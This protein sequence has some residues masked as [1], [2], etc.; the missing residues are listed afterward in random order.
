MAGKLPTFFECVLVLGGM[1]IR[2]GVSIARSSRCTMALR[3]ISRDARLVHS[4]E[5]YNLR[6]PGQYFDSETGKHYNYFR[7]YDPALGRYVES[8]LIGLSGGLNTYSYVWQAP[9]SYLDPHGLECWWLDQGNAVQ[10]K[11]TGLRRQKPTGRYMAKQFFPAPDPTSP[12]IAIGPKPPMPQPGMQLVWRT[13]FHDKGYWEA[14]FS[15]HSWATYVCKE[16]CGKLTF[17]PGNMDLGKKW[18]AVPH[19][20]YDDLSYGPWSNVTTPTGPWDLEGVHGPRSRG[21]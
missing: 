15:C 17:L 3:R 13:V 8:D 20:D 1:P 9:L 5:A 19:S 12:S 11:P 10:C 4:Q 7:D 18:D 21:H 14:E 2:R 16:P 6:F